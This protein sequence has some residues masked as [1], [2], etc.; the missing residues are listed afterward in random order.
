MSDLRAKSA[1]RSELLARRAAHDAGTRTAAAALV[2]CHLLAGLN[3]RGV[4]QVAA[5]AP[6]GAEPGGAE[7]PAVLRQAGL[8][9]LLPVLLPD[10]DL[11]WAEYAGP[12][13]LVAGPRGLREPAGPRCGVAA[14]ARVDA[15]V[16]P[17]VAV[18]VRGVRLG[19][20][21]GSYDRALARVPAGVPVVALL[22]DGE[23]VAAVPAE[24]HDR[25]VTAVVTPSG[26]WR[27][28]P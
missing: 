24:P 19:R 22:H 16:V 4:G 17:A 23:L 2:R 5:H 9:V 10:R 8:R 25:S 6:F 28:L 26:G 15:V 18:D 7:L 20:G 11:D 3:E 1:V 12:E 21:G 14:V 27:D 13:S